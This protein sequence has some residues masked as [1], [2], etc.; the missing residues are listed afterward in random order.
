MKN[1][2]KVV[3]LPLDYSETLLEKFK[4]ELKNPG[5]RGLVIIGLYPHGT[6][7]AMSVGAECNLPLLNYALDKLKLDLL[8]KVVDD[9]DD[10]PSPFTTDTTNEKAS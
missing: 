8:L 9:S 1:R 10:E 4:G 3:D 2:L 6:D 7:V 5:Y